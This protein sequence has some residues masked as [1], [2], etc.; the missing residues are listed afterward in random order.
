MLELGCGISTLVGL[1]LA[2]SVRSY[3]LTDQEYVMKLL[4]QNLSQNRQTTRP[5]SSRG[6][7]SASTRDKP[8]NKSSASASNIIAHPLDWEKDQISSSFP[9]AEAG[10]DAIIA[11]D[12]IYNEALIDPLVQTCIDTCRLRSVDA[13]ENRHNAT[14]CVVAQQLRSPEVFEQWLAAFHTAFQVWRV[15]DEELSDGLKSDSGFVVH[16]GIL[17]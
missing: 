7:K 15:P 6:R 2:P 17:R 5:A 16:I 1:T 10:F 8:S 14:I 3:I 11:C 12:C 13:S 9:G 4:H